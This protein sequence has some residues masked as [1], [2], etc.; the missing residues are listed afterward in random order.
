MKLQVQLVVC[1][2]E[3]HEATFTA[4]VVLEQ[5]CQ[6]IEPLGLTLTAAKQLLTA[7]P[8]RR[9][10]QQTAAFVTARSPG[11]HCGPSRGITGYHTRTFRTRFGTV[12]V[13]SPRL[14]HGRC[15]WRQPTPVRPRSA[16]LTETM[17]PAL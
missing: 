10:E 3:G 16:R 1:D 6:R 15:Q 4:V 17:A 9:V 8:Q 5:A 14:Y 7:R 2:D 13:T 12:T 11:D